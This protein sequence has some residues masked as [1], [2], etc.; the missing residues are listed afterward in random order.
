[1]MSLGPSRRIG[2]SFLG[3]LAGDLAFMPCF[4]T[5]FQIQG[6]V[7]PRAGL[8]LGL[9]QQV[10]TAFEVWPL[11]SIC[12]FAGWVVVGIP[13]V[14]FI[15]PRTICLEP[16][17]TLIPL[18]TAMGPL[19]IFLWVVLVSLPEVPDLSLTLYGPAYL[20]A[21]LISGIAFFVHCFLIKRH[22]V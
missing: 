13:A 20:L 8:S 18:G 4:V 1:M 14:L 12:V 10:L 3:F 17:W 5:L 22:T 15:S 6:F 21:G 19:A 16:W 2:Y 7:H 9:Y 11:A